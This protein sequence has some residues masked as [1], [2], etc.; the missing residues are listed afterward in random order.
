MAGAPRVCDADLRQQRKPQSA[1]STT[2]SFSSENLLTAASGGITLAYDPA[3]RLYQTAGGT[4]GTTRFAYDGTDLIAEYNGSNVLQRRFVHG[5]GNDQPIAWYEGSG[6]SDRRFLHSDE[7]GSVVAVTNSS[8]TV[9]SVNTYDE[10]GI[11]RSTNTGRFQYSGQTWLP[12]LGIYYYKARIYSPTLGRFLQTDPIGYAGGM[13]SY[14]YVGA[15]PVNRADPGGTECMPIVRAHGGDCAEDAAEDYVNN[16]VDNG[17]LSG[18]TDV[19]ALKHDIINYL[20][21]LIPLSTVIS[22]YESQVYQAS[23][24]SAF[25]IGAAPAGLFDISARTVISPLLT[26]NGYTKI[27]EGEVPEYGIINFENIIQIPSGTTRLEMLT[28]SSSFAGDMGDA[29]FGWISSGSFDVDL[30]SCANCLFGSISVISVVVIPT[31]HWTPIQLPPGTR[32]IGIVANQTTP[33]GTVFQ[34]WGRRGN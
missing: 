13:N 30:R 8:G 15:E 20:R 11:P 16:K 3:M 22:N 1:G 14:G 18:N 5:P 7:R 25:S 31:P 17:E 26:Y 6:T 27:G 10:Y 21:D 23:W 24:S 2:Y 28:S 32:Y 12:E 19:G 4:P 9:L 33:G 29:G 34:V